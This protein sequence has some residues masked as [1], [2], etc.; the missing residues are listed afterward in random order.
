MVTVAEEV[1]EFAK[2][3]TTIP[4]FNLHVNVSSAF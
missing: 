3:A 2:K 4:F 1:W